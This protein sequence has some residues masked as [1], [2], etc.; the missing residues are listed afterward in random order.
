[1]FRISLAFVA[2]VATSVLH[3]VRADQDLDSLLGE[4]TAGESNLASK[5]PALLPEAPQAN[6][7][8]PAPI[9][10]FT[11][12]QEL[13]ADYGDEMIEAPLAPSSPQP[14]MPTPAAEPPVNF[15][16]YIAD[17]G[18]G[19][20]CVGCSHR[21]M[22]HAPAAGCEAPYVCRPHQAPNLPPT[23]TMLQY[24]QSDSYNSNVW[25]GFAAE[26]QRRND[27][28]YKCTEGTC[29][30]FTKGHARCGCQN[31]SGCQHTASTCD[32]RA[33]YR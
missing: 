7:L 17:G 27:H 4:L 1:M 28:L 18:M 8:A 6:E 14:A 33:N 2:I 16:Q 3:H 19:D 9:Q 29:D 15:N 23:S 30:C 32:S 31:Q 11:S 5:S 13:T 12:T 24:L 26:R 10:R 22:H 25:A 21:G 20:A